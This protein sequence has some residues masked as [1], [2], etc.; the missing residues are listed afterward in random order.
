MGRP[1]DGEKSLPTT[2]GRPATGP[3]TIIRPKGGEAL[4]EVVPLLH[5][6]PPPSEV[7]DWSDGEVMPLIIIE[8]KSEMLVPTKTT[9]GLLA[10]SDNLLPKSHEMNNSGDQGVLSAPISPNRVRICQR[11]EVYSMC[12]QTSRD[13]T[14]DRPGVVYSK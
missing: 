5:K 9:E 14:C 10:D 3:K 12:L 11:K 2:D 4:T 8:N 6:A 13:F 1:V 7:P